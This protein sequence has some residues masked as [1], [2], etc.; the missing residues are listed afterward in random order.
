MLSYLSRSGAV[1]EVVNAKETLE[2]KGLE[3][4]KVVAKAADKLTETIDAVLSVLDPDH[5]GEGV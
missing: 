3:E 5:P 4:S 2:T 1:F